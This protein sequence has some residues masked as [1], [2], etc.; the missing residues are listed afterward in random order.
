VTAVGVRGIGTFFPNNVRA[1]DFWSP[2]VVDSW[3]SRSAPR[4]QVEPKND[5]EAMVMRA[6]ADY[7]SDP[8]Q[9]SSLRHV[10]DD[11]M[12]PSAL[13][14][15]AARA[16]VANAQIDPSEIDLLLVH[17]SIPD[18]L[19]TNAACTIHA[20]L[21]LPPRCFSLGVEAACNSWQMN[22][23]LARD[24]IRA[25]R[26]RNALLVQWCAV[27][28]IIPPH[29]HHAPWFGDGA[30]A[31]VLGTVK[32]GFGILGA[33]HVTDGDL[34]NTLVAGVPGGRWYDEGRVTLY[35]EDIERAKRMFVE[36]ADCAAIAV[37][38]AL[39]DAGVAKDDVDFYACHQGTAWLGRVTQQAAGLG[40]ARTLDTFPRTGNL[41]SPNI[42]VVL[43][44]AERQGLLHA[45]DVVVTHAGGSGLT[46]SSLVLRWRT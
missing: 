18:F 26:A 13:G 44:E 41:G 22:V 27:T 1:N 37:D 19:D 7:K 46:Y 17:A 11:G 14:I 9:G 45:G 20:A 38:A 32:D 31:M 34:Q 5:N 2:E 39:D 35:P 29:V 24:M 36:S 42:P 43:A 12:A 28:R 15:G 30:S 33:S 3:R 4:P 16:A 8:F 25:G 23:E 40:H 10:I 21:G 6:L